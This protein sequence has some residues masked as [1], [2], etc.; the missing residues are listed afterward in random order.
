MSPTSYLAA[1]PRVDI[2]HYRESP[3]ERQPREANRRA[4]RMEHARAA[5]RITRTLF[6]AQSLGSA[7]Q[8]AIFPIVAIL[9][10]QLSGRPAPAGGAAVGWWAG[11]G[12]S[13]RSPVVLGGRRAFPPPWRP[14]R[15]RSARGPS[16]MSS[17]GG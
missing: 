10:A 13:P 7:G 5:R 14:P 11:G 4:F 6:L 15:R 16:P 1:P 12:P 9:G 17:S 3:Q 2:L 8:V